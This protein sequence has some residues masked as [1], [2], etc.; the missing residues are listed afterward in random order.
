MGLRSASF[1]VL[2][3]TQILVFDP[4]RSARQ[5]AAR[6]ARRHWL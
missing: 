5:P 3:V 4:C 1:G 6:R 2:D